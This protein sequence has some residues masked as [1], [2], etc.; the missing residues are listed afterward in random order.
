MTAVKQGDKFRVT[1]TLWCATAG[2]GVSVLCCM[3]DSSG[4]LLSSTNATYKVTSASTYESFSLELS[5]PSIPTNF[6]YA[7]FKI[8]LTDENSPVWV[9][10]LGIHKMAS[11][12]LIVDGA[13]TAGKINASA[14]TADKIA[15]NAITASKIAANTITGDKISAGT[16]SAD[17]L[18]IQSRDSFSINPNFAN[19]TSTYPYGTS[20][21]VDGG[22]SKVTV[23][24]RYVA[25]FNVSNASSQQ[26]MRLNGDF[27]NT[28]LNLDGM[29]YIGLEVKY[30]LTSGTNPA[31]ACML[32]D[33]FY[34]D[35]SYDRLNLSL[36][37]INPTVTTNTWYTAKRVFKVSNIQKTFKSVS[38]YLLANWSSETLTAKTIQFAS[39][40]AYA[41]T[42]QD[43]LT[44]TWTSG[45]EI[46]GA[47]IKTGTLSADKIT[48]GTLDANK[49]NV[50]NIKAGNIVSGTI[51]ASKIS[52]TNLNASNITSGT[53]KGRTIEGGTIRNGSTVI[54]SNG[55]TVNNGAIKIKNKAG[56]T[57]LSSDSNGNLT[58]S[59]TIKSEAGN[60]L[61]A[62]LNSGGITFRDSQKSEEVLR[63]GTSFSNGNRDINGVTFAM[64]QYSDRI[65]FRHIAKPS[66]EN[67]WDGSETTY[68]F[69]EMWSADYNHS[70]GKNYKGINVFAPMYLSQKIRFRNGGDSYL[71]EITP[72]MTWNNMN[73]LMGIFGD[74][75]TII[76][77]KS[78]DNLHARIVVTEENHP[79]TGDNIKSW[80]NWN[81]SGY[82]V[83]N[84][85]FSGNHVN[86]YANTTTRTVS[87]TAGV[88]AEGNQVRVNFEN[89]QIKDG[90]AILSIPKRYRGINEGYTIASIVKKGRGDVW[91]SEEEE[92][93][94]IIEA[95]NDIKI[96]IE[97]IIK[98]T[99]AV[100]ARTLKHEDSICYEVPNEQPEGDCC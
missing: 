56:N 13:I 70:N 4:S 83:H 54:D 89:V 86:S 7:S 61:Y 44:Q 59:G 14:V 27:F 38:G 17:K 100:V 87:N 25:Q 37:S 2:Q 97:V 69:M 9:Y 43:Y 90:K 63:I 50:T 80:G 71:H 28:G 62:A 58:L 29:Q 35:G 55:L 42:E 96:N 72:N 19:W 8:Q 88:M 46:N 79:G 24:N 93:R 78:A 26:G 48:T 6:S 47:S 73:K 60:G 18:K 74:N 51:D 40:N 20:S 66:L 23:D 64:P 21:W 36:K 39:A 16:I 95:E 53:L 11:G 3:R 75:G 76:G 10:G 65:S 68:T 31:G 57:V 84:A 85:T 34:T 12:E 22:I 98:L 81:C 67:G 52:V 30:R 5:V 91:V 49:V 15:A 32:L 82:T 77:Y 45:T 33:I 99:E 92:E 1:G 94:F 41:C